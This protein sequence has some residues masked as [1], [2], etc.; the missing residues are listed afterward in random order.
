[1]AQPDKEFCSIRLMFP[2]ETD[3]K[4]ITIKKEIAIALKDIPEAQIDF[5]IV[6]SQMLIPKT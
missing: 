3:D 5:R 6:S 1:M 4:A 2:V